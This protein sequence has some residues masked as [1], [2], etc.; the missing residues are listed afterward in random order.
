MHIGYADVFPLLNNLEKY[1]IFGPLRYFALLGKK[2][3]PIPAHSV[4][5]KHCPQAENNRNNGSHNGEGEF[6]T[7][8]LSTEEDGVITPCAICATSSY[9]ESNSNNF[10][11]N[12]KKN[13]NNEAGQWLSLPES[14]TSRKALLIAMNIPLL[15]VLPLPLPADFH[16]ANGAG[17]ILSEN[18]VSTASKVRRMT[19]WLTSLGPEVNCDTKPCT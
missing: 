11:S 3:P 6:I 13:N 10:E 4:A 5:V 9:H 1:R 12:D 19:S 16:I 7:S 2:P 8:C 18:I 15:P 17:I 14:F